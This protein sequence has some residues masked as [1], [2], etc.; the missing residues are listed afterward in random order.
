MSDNS[1]KTI[2]IDSQEIVRLGIRIILRKIEGLT[3]LAEF[4][5]GQSAVDKS[6]A[7]RP[8]L[9]LLDIELPQLDGIQATALLKKSTSAKV[10]ILTSLVHERDVM[11]ALD[12]GADGYCLRGL[13]PAHLINVIQCILGGGLWL[14]SS[15]AKIVADS[16]RGTVSQ[17]AP[18]SGVMSDRRLSD[19]ELQVLNLVVDGLTNQEVADRLNVSA[20]TVKT[21]MRHLMD[22][23]GVS[24]R[25]QA[26]VKAVH[27]GLVDKRARSAHFG[28]AS[29]LRT[30]FAQRTDP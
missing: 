22:K 16:L 11:A 12:A 29:A 20:E 28:S 26:A 27:D 10:I 14:D 25:T 17:A 6:P 19:R 15:A 18:P 2:L 23:L 9:I 5:D 24:D 7:L 8:D 4:G 13:G 30:D 21:H 3:L 1:I